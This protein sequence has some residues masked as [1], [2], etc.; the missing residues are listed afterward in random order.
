MINFSFPTIKLGKYIKEIKSK[1]KNTDLKQDDLIVYGVTNVEG[2]TI[3]NNKASEDLGDYTVLSANLF[4]YNPY[5]INVGSIGLSSKDTFGLVSP[6]YVV[7][8]TTKDINSEFLLH[9][10]KSSLGINLIKWYGDRGGVRS[11]LRFSDL[12]K[13]DFP[14]ISLEQQINLLDK[15]KKI[16]SCL[17]QFNGNLSLDNISSLRQSILQQAVE[18]KLC[19][20]DPADEPTSV[21]LGKIQLE[22]DKLIGKK[23]IKRQKDLPSI[24]DEEKPFD[25]PQGWEWCRLGILLENLKYGTSV[26]CTYDSKNSVVLRIPNVNTETNKID[27]SD[28]KYADLSPNEIAELSLKENDILLIRSNGSASLVGRIAVVGKVEKNI[29]Y[30]G[31]LM[32]LR[33]YNMA[34]DNFYLKRVFNCRFLRNLIE[35]PIR[36]TTGV[37]N[38]NSTE[39]SNLLVPLPP[40]A[41]QQRIVEKVDKLMALC[42]EMEKEVT[43]AKKHASELMEAVLQE[44]LSNAKEEYHCNVIKFAAKPQQEQM[45]FVAAARGKIKESTWNSLVTRAKE[46]AS[47][48]N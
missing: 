9:Y 17:C 16:D 1:V 34:V 48:E 7:F 31:Y 14:D 37:K 3:T 35:I 13:I 23:K 2:V 26:P 18:G 32:R 10:L 4:V 43:N 47:E 28:I 11:A 19:E 25:L 33:T 27:L 41:E 29:C 42:D 30:A 15:I 38:I 24:T 46:L 20:Q 6:A 12:K 8:E 44:A 21:L 40:L 22:K 39:V 36:T 5:R 45:P